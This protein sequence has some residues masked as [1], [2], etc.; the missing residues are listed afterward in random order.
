MAHSRNRSFF[1]P[2]VGLLALLPA[3]MAA[4]GEALD[5]LA[6]FYRE[7]Q[8]LQASFEQ[9]VVGPEG[10][11]QE[12]S[13][14][15]VWI[16]RPDHF[17]WD[18]RRPYRQLIVADGRTVKFYDPE[19]EQVTVRSYARGMGH[20]PS[21]VLAGGGDLEEHFHVRDQGVSDGLAWVAL[22][23][24]KPEEAGFRTA[25]VGLAADP[26]RV[27]RLEFTDAFGNRTR[28]RFEG[29]RLNPPLKADRFRFEAPPGTDVLG[30]GANSNQ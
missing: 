23:P 1:Y 3:P 5:R 8:A 30:T 18:Y 14:G 10:G 2:L 4:A 27:R 28:I 7:T 12:R 20:T 6:T 29:I 13:G 25:R 11:V 21:M 19:M 24:R 26:V 16:Q 9:R 22:E 15:K 17:R